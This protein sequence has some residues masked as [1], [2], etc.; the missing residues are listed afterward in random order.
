MP[1]YRTF[2][3]ALL[4]ATLL[5]GSALAASA[6]G[7][8][9]IV[10]DT[11]GIPH[12]MAPDL[13]SA[14]RGLGYAEMEGE[15]ET[16]LGNVATAR[17][18]RAEYFGPG[19]GNA[20]VSSDIQVRTEGIP[21]RARLWLAAGGGFQRAIIDAFVAGA[22]E[23]AADRG[24]TID[25]SFRRVL[26]FAATDVPAGEQ[27]TVHFTFMPEQDNIPAL[28]AAWQSGG[29]AAAAA[30]VRSFT[31]EGS[32]GWA[33]APRK[34]ASGNA[35][36]MGNPHLPWG[37]NQPIPGLGLFQWMEVNILIGDPAHPSLDA[38]GVVFP[39]APYIGIGFNDDLG[40]THTNDTI[41]N[42]NLYEITIDQAGFYPFGKVRLPVIPT[43]DTLKIRNADGSFSTQTFSIYHAIQG[44][45]VARNGN[46]ALALR[47]AGLD[48]P[49]IVS[50][51]WHM[52]LAHD[53]PGFIAANAALQMP[54]FNVIY[55]DRAGH[56]MYVFGGQQPKRAGGT[57]ADYDGIL[58][59]SDPA[60]MWTGTLGWFDLPRAIDPPGGFVANS[61]NPP[62]TSAFPAPPSLDRT[63]FPAWIAPD[64]MDL[65]P[66][67]AA[68]FLLSKE[69]FTT[70]ELLAGKES[71]HM[72]LADRVLPD[73][74]LAATSSNDP[75]AKEAAAVLSA[76]DRSA[77]AGSRGGVLFESWWNRVSVDP[78]IAKDTT[79]D[80]YSPHPRFRVGWSDTAPLSTPNGLADPAACLPDLVAAANEVRAA[81][82]RLD[83]AWGDVHRTVLVTHD[84]T[85]ANAIP[86]ADDAESGP[87]DPFG[88]VRVVNPFPAPD[89]SGGL[90][91]YGGDGYVQLVEFT[92]SGARARMLL[93]YGNSSRPGSPHITDQLAAFDAKTLLPAWR[94]PS[95][96]AA[97]AARTETY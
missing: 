27:N 69:K 59:G 94:T 53:L 85:F 5:S 21:D 71:T 9:R 75:V 25:P 89:G 32:N 64:F 76:W 2:A 17:G 56:V 7:G 65:R 13:L 33:I 11:Y 30:L 62:W 15:A 57:F 34:S 68:V 26:P 77:D 95:E 58:D 50:Q 1:L 3:S 8:G 28:L 6:A 52:M 87:D 12:I 79:D 38:S 80:F 14:V 24:D 16:L 74:L 66:Q 40:W 42:T 22:N 37:V 43:K 35:I 31:P 4:G 61:N 48:K 44:P 78:A 19:A 23:Y 73:L 10:W 39:G 54:F 67:N 49:A 92:P 63:R 81:H 72:A 93:G 46:K 41:Q 82:G 47:V 88:P 96:I 97:H 29:A 45:L 18:R 51:Y 90:W 55:A 36:L 70:D 86:V 91:S 60:A 84:A 20:N 83:V